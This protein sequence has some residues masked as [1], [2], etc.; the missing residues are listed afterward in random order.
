[1]I[2]DIHAN[3]VALETVLQNAPAYDRV[4]C[5]GDVV[6]YG[7]APNECVARVQDLGAL[8]L[9][10]NHDRAV[11]GGLALEAFTVNARAGLKWTRSVL[12]AESREWLAARQPLQ[13]LPEYDVTLVHASLRDP[14]MEYIEDAS[15]AAKNFPL[16]ETS[17]CFFGHTHRPIAY[18][19]RERERLIRREFLLQIGAYLLEPKALVNP[20]SVGQPRDGDPRAAFG[21]YD[22]D[23]H[24]LTHYRIEYDIARTQRAMA[25]VGL[26]A[27]LIERLA[28][29]A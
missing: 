20:G 16:L 29:G 13:I 7:P 9:A 24:T 5:L 6:G 18:R 27:H 15:V 25:E 26:P 23:T 21:I 1:M 17:F 19:L 4:W 2:S 22:T 10:G 11:T 8:A 12:T 28:V 14:L 3:L